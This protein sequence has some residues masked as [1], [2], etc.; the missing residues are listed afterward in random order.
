MSMGTEPRPLATSDFGDVL[1]E[2]LCEV[3]RQE[4]R[5]DAKAAQLLTLAGTL[6]TITTAGTVVIAHHA[7]GFAVVAPMVTAAG[8]WV[9]AVVVVLHRIVRPRL[10]NGGS[11]TSHQ[12]EDL[13][14]VSLVEYRVILINQVSGIVARRYRAVRLA[15]D[16]L[17]AGFAPLLL[18]AA[19]SLSRI[20]IV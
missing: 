19:G 8:L 13:R 16:L 6:A 4:T 12:V 15:A 10:R 20:L 14:G 3:T 1:R 5:V 7:P 17:L 11:F 18:M 9:A 2:A